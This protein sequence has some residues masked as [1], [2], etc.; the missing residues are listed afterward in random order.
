MEVFGEK[1]QAYEKLCKTSADLIER[2]LDHSNIK[3]H[4]ISWRCKN[5][6][7]LEKK[8]E[9]KKKYKSLDE[10]TDIAGIRI[11][12]NYSDEVDLI[13]AI[14]EKEFKVD[15]ENS[16]DKRIAIDPERFGYL[17]LHYVV[18][19]SNNRSKLVEYK[20]F[21]GL[22]IEVQIRS[23]LQ[24]TWA[25]IEHDIGY[26]SQFEVPK[27]IKRKFSRLAGLLELADQE[28]ISIRNEQQK[29]NEALASEIDLNSAQI[30]LDKNSFDAFAKKNSQCIALDEN[31]SLIFGR[32]LTDTTTTTTLKQLQT[33][34]IKTIKQLEDS[35]IKH[36]D[37]IVSLAQDMHRLMM[38]HYSNSEAT[39]RRGV[40]TVYLSHVL[41]AHTKDH[42]IIESYLS[43]NSWDNN[44]ISDEFREILRNMFN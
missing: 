25:E 7:S 43:E 27:H 16:I 23:I 44:K 41:V 17:S 34:G 36:Q 35:L 28:F 37:K 10:I 4:S 8:I 32:V 19:L 33:S 6:K 24:H 26:K 14:I 30:G 38:T 42:D 21:K 1:H 5:K 15:K 39:F 3:V 31:I 20:A 40:C 11:I 2:L 29:Y 22:K 18:E 9:K 13:A 12:T